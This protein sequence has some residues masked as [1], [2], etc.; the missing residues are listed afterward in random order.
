[1]HIDEPM[2][3][4]VVAAA[5]GWSEQVLQVLAEGSAFQAASG[6]PLDVVDRAL[7]GLLGQQLRP[8]LWVGVD[9][10][11][12][13]CR[14]V[15]RNLDNPSSPS[16][17]ASL[18][19]SRSAIETASLVIWIL[20]AE[21]RTE[22]IRRTL[23][24]GLESAY[25]EHRFRGSLNGKEHQNQ[26]DEIHA[27][28]RS[29]SIS[30]KP[31]KTATRTMVEFSSEALGYDDLL[32]RWQVLSGV[33]H[34]YAWASAAAAVRS[35]ATNAQDARPARNYGP[36]LAL[37]LE[38][39]VTGFV[40]LNRAFTLWNEAAGRS[41]ENGHHSAIPVARVPRGSGRPAKLGL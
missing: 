15:E 11:R 39:V 26:R 3:R 28:A 18:V 22:V 34:G 17:Y 38:V 27:L 7:K 16:V 40:V 4:G 2:A 33:A 25:E 9:A 35:P 20:A 41:Q 10:L 21:G 6:S 31:K 14:I 24:Q 13:A 29:F 23:I 32:G 36:N 30:G 19:L 1:M 5:A 37:H 8:A 12:S